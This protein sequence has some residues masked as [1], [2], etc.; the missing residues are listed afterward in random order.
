MMIKKLLFFMALLI[1]CQ[2]MLA[3]TDSF[4]VFRY[5]PP[6]YFTKT[7]LSS[8][9]LYT[10]KNSDT[11][12]CTITLLDSMPAK[13]DA[14]KDLLSQWNDYVLERLPKA[15]DKP[16]QVFTNEV[17][18]GWEST[19][20]VGNFYNNDRKCVVIL[21]SFR[22]NTQ[23]ACVIFEMSDRLFQPVVENFSKNLHLIR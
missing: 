14:M 8:S 23:S 17:W 7:Q 10:L 2:K 9:V 3:Q 4:S 20:A 5:E 22:K 12:I 16:L 6:A 15:N 18:D 13:E 11:S 19:V 1:S 21:N